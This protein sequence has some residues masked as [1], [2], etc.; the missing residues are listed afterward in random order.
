MSGHYIFPL[1]AFIFVRYDVAFIHRSKEKR[2][3]GYIGAILGKKCKKTFSYHMSLDTYKYKKKLC[4][5]L[6]LVQ[7]ITDMGMKE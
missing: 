5:K 6:P 4:N 7:F 1:S 3:E 2:E